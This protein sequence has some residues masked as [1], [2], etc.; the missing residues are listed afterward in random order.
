MELRIESYSRFRVLVLLSQIQRA[1]A[2]NVYQQKQTYVDDKLWAN[3]CEKCATT[4]TSF[5]N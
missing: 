4:Q 1:G 2:R 5:I 3:S